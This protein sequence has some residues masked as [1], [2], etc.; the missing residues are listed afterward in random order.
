[1]KELKGKIIIPIDKEN[2]TVDDMIFI[3]KDNIDQLTWDDWFEEQFVYGDTQIL[4]KLKKS[5]NDE[6]RF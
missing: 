1:M 6:N 5:K 4:Q 2:V 3:S